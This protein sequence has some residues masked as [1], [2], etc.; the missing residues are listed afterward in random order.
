MAVL[1]SMDE[2]KQRSAFGLTLIIV[3]VPRY[4]MYIFLVA[5]LPFVVQASQMETL[6]F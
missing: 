2:N 5:I 3:M 6:G 1:P 4:Y